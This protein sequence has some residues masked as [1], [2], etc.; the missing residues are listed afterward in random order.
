[1]SDYFNCQSSWDTIHPVKALKIR[2]R[3]T[4]ELFS[5]GLL[6]FVV[7]SGIGIFWDRP[8]FCLFLQHPFDPEDDPPFLSITNDI[9]AKKNT[10]WIARSVINNLHDFSFYFMWSSTYRKSSFKVLFQASW[11]TYLHC[12][13]TTSNCYLLN[14]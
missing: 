3:V 13:L 2:V 1:M 9:L 12:C 14:F 7:S 5:P 6:V 4:R 8:K 10:P 11:I